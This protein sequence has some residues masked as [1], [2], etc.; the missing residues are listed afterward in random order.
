MV[1][2]LSRFP[3]GAAGA[4]LLLLRIACAFGAFSAHLRWLLPL[5]LSVPASTV[6]IAIALAI[7]LG[8]GTRTTALLLAA[9]TVSAA[10]TGGGNIALIIAHAGSCAA[11][12]LLGPG[13]YSIDA[14]AFGRRVVQFK[15]RGRD[16]KKDS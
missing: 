10:L 16:G 6:A 2:F 7:V 11:L 13:A 15:P 12:A 3:D 5:R 8:F 9:A 14:N 4:G 1:T